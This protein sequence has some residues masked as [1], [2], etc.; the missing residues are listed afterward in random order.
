MKTPQTDPSAMKSLFFKLM[1]HKEGWLQGAISL[2]LASYYGKKYSYASIPAADDFT[3]AIADS[4]GAYLH[5]IVIAGQFEPIDFFSFDPEILLD[6]NQIEYIRLTNEP[7]IE[8][9]VQMLQSQAQIPEFAAK[10]ATWLKSICAMAISFAIADSAP[11]YCF[12]RFS[13]KMIVGSRNT[14]TKQIFAR[15][16]D[17]RFKRTDET[18]FVFDPDLITAISHG[19]DLFIFDK[20]NFFSIFRYNDHI[21]RSADIALKAIK[22]A[23]PIENFELFAN[24]CEGKISQMKKLYS[25]AKDNKMEHITIEQLQE[26]IHRLKLH[27][28]IDGTGERKKIIY[29]SQFK[30]EF[31]RLINDEYVISA[32]TGDLYTTTQKHSIDESSEI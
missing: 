7:E 16:I 9:K 17:K 25:I 29:Q 30:D 10:P 6:Q 2:Y 13:S 15:L 5:E 32:L 18:I 1:S 20:R 11:I 14:G 27:I 4:I 22:D 21:L 3:K 24:D 28:T 19:D 8:R 23:L 31:I 26:A 12:V